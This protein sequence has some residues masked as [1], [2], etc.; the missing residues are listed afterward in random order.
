MLTGV[1]AQV[2]HEICN[3]L[4]AISK[5]RG[6]EAFD[7][8]VTVFLPAQNWPEPAA[9]EF[10]TKMRDLDAKAFRKYFADFVRASRS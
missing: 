7:F 10:A 3:F 1:V 6:Q 8:F 9:I 2:L 4:Q 5:A